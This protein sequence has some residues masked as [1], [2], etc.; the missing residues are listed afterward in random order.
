MGFP[1]S[2]SI[3]S[4]IAVNR[5]RNSISELQ[6][7][8]NSNILIRYW[9]NAQFTFSLCT[10]YAP[11]LARIRQLAAAGN[12]QHDRWHKW[13]R[14]WYTHPELKGSAT[15]SS[16]YDSIF[17]FQ[18]NVLPIIVIHSKNMWNVVNIRLVYWIVYHLWFSY[19]Y[20]NCCLCD[21]L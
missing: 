8:M 12:Y 11:C 17:C 4:F 18:C 7:D 3:N 6:R 9:S 19:V 16:S 1:V 14:N 13:S 20:E 10:E 5:E 2:P 15:V 21:L